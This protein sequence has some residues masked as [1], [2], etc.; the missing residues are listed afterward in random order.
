[1]VAPTHKAIQEFV[2]KLA[3]CWEEYTSQGGK[4]LKDLRIYRVLSS[5]INKE[6]M[7]AGCEVLQL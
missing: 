7:L 2:A 1:M 3:R 6:A 4:D 5:D